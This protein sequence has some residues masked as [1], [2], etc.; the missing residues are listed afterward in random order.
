MNVLKGHS[1]L[2]DGAAA[3]REA[4][5]SW[6]D[7]EIASL[8]LLLIYHSSQQSAVAVTEAL[9]ERFS[10]IPSAGCSTAG[11]FLDANRFE[12]SLVVMG[13]H[14]PSI[15]W[16]V[17]AI[18]DVR[19]ATLMQI[20]TLLTEGA[21]QFGDQLDELDPQHHFSIL[22]QDGLSMQEESVTA[23]VSVVLQNVPLIGGSAGDDLRFVKTEQIANGVAYE[24]AAVM[25]LGK[26]KMPFQ[27]IK[28]QHYVPSSTDFVVTD[29]DIA[30]RTVYSLN[31]EPAA[32]VFARAVGRQPDEL[33]HELFGKHPLIYREQQEYYVRSIQQVGEDR[34][35]TFY[36][37]V[38]QGSLLD[39]GE[40]Y[41][42]LEAL[43]GRVTEVQQ[44]LGEGALLLIF[45]CI[46]CKLELQEGQ[47]RGRWAE[48]LSQLAPNMIGFDTYGEQLN[49][50][51]INQTVVA[52]VFGAER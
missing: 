31:G 8:D 32:D 35:L 15:E 26:S 43:A 12:G 7:E 33:D 39:L 10:K 52:M 16:H 11:E 29:A 38:E 24:H 23:M 45:S 46:L 3:L 42:P 30:T 51:H 47:E 22:L 9:K 25:I 27:I 48:T 2:E 36:C 5:A 40:R 14:S 6:S 37:A 28:H 21:E 1:Q 13:I 18:P 44:A 34:S 17:G 4:T 49:G 50:V 20:S 41:A 19:S